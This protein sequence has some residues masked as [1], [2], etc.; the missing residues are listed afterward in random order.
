MGKKQFMR[1]EYEEVLDPKVRELVALS[2]SLVAG[3]TH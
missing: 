3:C 2:A 1:F